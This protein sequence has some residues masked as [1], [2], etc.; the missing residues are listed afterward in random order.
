MSNIGLKFDNEK[1]RLDLISPI[2]VEELAK[3]LTFGA[4]KYAAWNWSKGIAYSRILAAMLRHLMAYLRGESKDPET[5]LSHIAHLMCGCMFLLH[6]ERYR[7][8]LDDREK[9]AYEEQK[10]Q[11]V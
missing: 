9:D 5:G 1:P 3:V 11:N 6:F 2:A 8:D 10:T 4:K 7:P